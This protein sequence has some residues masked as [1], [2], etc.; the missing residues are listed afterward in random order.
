MIF[1]LEAIRAEHGDCFLLHYGK[2][3]QEE[4]KLVLIDGGPGPAG[5]KFLLPRLEALRKD[6]VGEEGTLPLE[7]VMVSHID[8]D[9]VGGLLKLT[10]KVIEED[11]DEEPKLVEAKTLWHNAF[12]D[13]IGNEALI[14]PSSLGHITASLGS[15]IDVGQARNAAVVLASVNEGRT[16]RD[17]ARRL[18]WK[19]N[20]PFKRL[21]QAR[22][23]KVTLAGGLKLTVLGPDA[24]RLEELRK[25]WDKQLKKLESKK[26][27][28]QAE[29]AEYLDESVAN[30]SSIVVLAEMG[31]G[32]KKR[33]MLLTGDARGDYVLRGL[34][35][36]G[37]MDGEGKIHVDLFKLPHHGSFYNVDEDLFERVTAD[38]YVVS[39]NGK[40]TNPEVATLEMLID[41]RAKDDAFTIHMTYAID[42]LV[43]PYPREKLKKSLAKRKKTHD[44]E[45]VCPAKKEKG[46]RM[47]L[48]S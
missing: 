6:R 43:D 36:A 26:K 17:D 8:D 3:D 41:S 31:T 5:R 45:V 9:H 25:E 30:L 37:L 11:D 4:S 24:E 33:R 23:S 22:K 48:G 14:T 20:A 32:K 44:F 29:A 46:M 2:D 47:D 16:L 42:E 38:H 10:R 1:S 18:G 15:V 19:A 27:K 35:R 13:I 21:V 40:Y 39:G 7:M 12:D 28:E 34:E